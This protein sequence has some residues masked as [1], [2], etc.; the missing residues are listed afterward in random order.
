MKTKRERM[1]RVKSKR[2]DRKRHTEKT[3]WKEYYDLEWITH[4]LENLLVDILL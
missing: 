1:K 2:D 3:K 4:E